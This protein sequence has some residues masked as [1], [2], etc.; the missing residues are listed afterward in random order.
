MDVIINRVPNSKWVSLIS[1]SNE[2]TWCCGMAIICFAGIILCM[3]PA[4]ERRRYLIGWVHIQNHNDVI[5]WKHFPCYWPFVRGVHWSSM[6]SSHKSQWRGALKF[7][8]ICAWTNDWANNRDA[9]DLRRHRAHYNVK[10]MWSLFWNEEQNIVLLRV[11]KIH[12]TITPQ[13]T[14]RLFQ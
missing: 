9:G 1:F 10:I 8:L 3:R 4:T 2:V 11:H 13:R 5:K 7:P 12:T 6:D 14:E